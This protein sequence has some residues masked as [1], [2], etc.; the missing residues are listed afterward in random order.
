[1]REV[2][3]RLLKGSAAQLAERNIEDDPELL[4]LYLLEIP[5]LLLGGDEIARHRIDAT[6]LKSRLRARGI[7]TA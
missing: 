3:E 6:E 7:E 4:R 5:V 1:M 2:V